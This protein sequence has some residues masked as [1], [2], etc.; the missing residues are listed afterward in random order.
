[1]EG[2]E[3]REQIIQLLSADIEKLF[4]LS[5]CFSISD[6]AAFYTKC[7]TH[8]HPSVLM[9]LTGSLRYFLWLGKW[10]ESA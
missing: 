7:S 10:E 3:E 8:A 6:T 9:V 2:S 4:H 1:M 5:L